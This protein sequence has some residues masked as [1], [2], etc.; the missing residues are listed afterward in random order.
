MYQGILNENPAVP[1]G[2]H[3]ASTHAPNPATSRHSI[4]VVEELGRLEASL[5]LS[6][7]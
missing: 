5:S 7:I 6:L 1:A 2:S 4:K 3:Q